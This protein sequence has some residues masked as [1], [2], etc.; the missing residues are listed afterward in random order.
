M[1]NTA[2][3]PMRQAP[4]LMRAPVAHRSV[5]ASRAIGPAVRKAA[6]Y[7]FLAPLII[8]FWFVFY[9][10]LPEYLNGMA[11][12]PF[13]TLG[14]IDRI[15]KIGMIVISCA[16]IASQWPRAR[17]LMKTLNPGLAAFMV[18]IPLS[19]VWSIDSDATLF[20]LLR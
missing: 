9:Q 2:K 15:L 5:P 20:D 13:S 4:K 11:F 7:V 8:L 3:R 16:V 18:L 12:K 14:T 10:N 17:M 6:G 1:K 19:A